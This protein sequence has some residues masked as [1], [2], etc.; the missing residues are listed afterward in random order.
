MYLSSKNFKKGS[1]DLSEVD[2]ISPFDYSRHFKETKA[3][4]KPTQ[5]DLLLG[6]IGSL[7]SPYLVK[8]GEVIG[9]SSSVAIIRP[10]SQIDARFLYYHLT[11]SWVQN[12]IEAIKSGAAQ[13]FISLEMLKSIPVKF[14]CLPMQQQIA[15]VLGRYDALLENYRVQVATLEKL[16]QELYQEWF[17]R[18]RC[19]G[20]EAGSTGELPTGWAR[21]KFTDVISVQSGGTPKTSEPNYWDGEVYWFSPGDVENSYYVLTTNKTI[22]EEG[23]KNC[24]SKLYPVDTVVITAR[25]TVGKCVM[26]GRPM[27]INQS[28][29]ALVGR[30]V[31][32]YFTF[33]KT[34]EMAEGLQK[35]ANGAVFSTIT[36]DNFERAE[37]LVPDA[38][39]LAVFDKLV[40]P[41]FGAIRN[42]L[43]QSEALRATRDALLPRLLSGQLLP[44]P[45]PAAIA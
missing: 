23:L 18:G 7:G 35:E 1:L 10:K 44:S 8:E 43:E 11:S 20:A 12:Y 19:P 17:V 9:I 29:Y 3:V 33:F 30:S 15:A 21:V 37:I 40:A 13:G 45:T 32:Q 38:E 6:I 26:L 24:N 27:A 14:P 42:Y 31:S 25:G 39:S 22:S 2:Y 41:M 34:L 36:T 5:N 16:A 4:T 28:N